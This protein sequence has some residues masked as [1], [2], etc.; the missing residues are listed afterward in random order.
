MTIERLEP[1]NHTKMRFLLE[2]LLLATNQIL[3]THFLKQ[4]CLFEAFAE[5]SQLKIVSRKE[6][7]LISFLY[8]LVI[9]CI[10]LDKN[11]ENRINTF[12]SKTGYFKEIY[13]MST[14]RR[15][16]WYH[17]NIVNILLDFLHF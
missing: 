1:M 8:S 7:I 15:N 6:L 3:V 4:K 17:K 9:T 14:L 2:K 5:F 16:N 10:A 12:Y 11:N 13:I